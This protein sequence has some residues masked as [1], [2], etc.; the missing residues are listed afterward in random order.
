MRCAGGIGALH[1]VDS[2]KTGG[3]GGAAVRCV[4]PTGG[5]THG[6]LNERP[7]PA[8]AGDWRAAAD[9]WPGAQ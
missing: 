9:T 1:A 7:G 2:T 5:Y 8:A 4:P 3:A 6:G